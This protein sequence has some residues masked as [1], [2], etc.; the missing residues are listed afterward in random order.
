MYVT[1][2]I[3]IDLQLDTL[4]FTKVDFK[5]L[6][7]RNLI[8]ISIRKTA[9]FSSC[10]HFKLLT[11]GKS[12]FNIGK[13]IFNIGKSIFNIGKSMFETHF[14]LIYSSVFEING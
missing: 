10:L 14:P 1:L 8:A 13:S 12:I 2:N 9:E 11:Y 3:C 7:L 4:I 5:C 6:C